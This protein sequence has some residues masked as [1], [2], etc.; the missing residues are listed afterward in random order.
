[1]TTA[2]LGHRNPKV[3]IVEVVRRIEAKRPETTTLLHEGVEHREPK[4][5]LLE[6]ARVRAALEPISLHHVEAAGELRAHTLRRLVRN[7]HPVLQEVQA[8]RTGR[9]GAGKQREP[10]VCWPQ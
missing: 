5:E 2:N 9:K 6:G 1:V 10:F 3:C 4:E 7:L 8:T